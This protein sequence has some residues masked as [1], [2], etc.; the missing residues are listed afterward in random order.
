VRAARALEPSGTVALA[1][2]DSVVDPAARFEV[3]VAAPLGDAVLVLVDAQDAH[4]PST[5][6]R[7]VA[8]GATRLALAP[9]APLTPASRYVLRVEGAS[10]RE[11]HDASGRAFVPATF[12]L[13]VAGD[14]PP[15]PARPK[16]K[17]RR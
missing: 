6:T 12:A 16:K 15:P 7:E 1:G 13:V 2:A 9:T 14:P 11:A 4:V 3:E 8:G 10:T 5:A 17:P